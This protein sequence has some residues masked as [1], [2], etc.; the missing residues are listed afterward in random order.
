M[1]VS[2]VV[3]HRT[4]ELHLGVVAKKTIYN[5]EYEVGL[6]LYKVII[7][8]LVV[9]EMLIGMGNNLNITLLKIRVRTQLTRQTLNR[10]PLIGQV[11][12]P[13]DKYSEFTA[14]KGVVSLIS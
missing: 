9:S 3:V 2:L 4:A 5:K 10:L 12:R 13:G 7:C 1:P 14:H 11:L 6:V 8:V